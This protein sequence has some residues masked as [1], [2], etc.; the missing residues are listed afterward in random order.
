MIVLVGLG[1]M[2]I[3]CAG[4]RMTMDSQ[5]GQNVLSGQFDSAFCDY[6]DKDTVRIVLVAGPVDQPRQVMHIRMFYRPKAGKTPLDPQATN[7]VVRYVV[8]EGDQAGLY[9]GGGLVM[10]RWSPGSGTF[11]ARLRNASLRLLDATE[12]FDPPT[13]LAFA[14]GTFTATRDDK[15]TGELLGQATQLLSRRLGYPRFADAE[16]LPA[17]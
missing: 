9:G 17:R 12:Q 16:P 11:S 15:R 3:G 8:F 13:T 4:G 2:A 5:V 6:Q 1:L 14:E 10:P 7:C